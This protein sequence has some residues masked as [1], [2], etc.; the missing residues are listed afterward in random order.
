MIHKTASRP[1]FEVLGAL[2][3][4]LALL[5]TARVAAQSVPEPD[6]QTLLN[7]LTILFWQRPGDAN[8]LLKL[9]IHSGA[10]FDLAGKGGTMA[11][12]G[13]ALFPD[14]ATREYVTEQLGGRLDVTTNYD[15]I[16]VTI[17]G[18][19]GEFE[20]MLE[21]LRGALV[22]TQL[23][24]ENVVR[25]RDARIKHLSERPAGVSEI[26][27]QAIAVRLFGTFPYG[28][29]PMGTVETVSKVD[30]GDLLLARERFLNAD[31][32]T[33]VVIGG[34]ERGRAVRAL[35]QLLGPW[36]KGDR[37]V[38]ATFRQPDPPDARVLV[39]NHPGATA[40]EIRLAV[41]GLARSDRDAAT[42]SL[43]AQIVRDRW[44][45]ASPDLSA[46]FVRHEAHVLPGMFV[47]GA[48]VPTASASKAVSAVR[49]VIRSFAQN[50]ETAPELERARTEILAE[51]SR[52][53]S[54]TELKEATADIWLYI[55]TYKLMPLAPQIRSVTLPDVQRVAARLFKDA[56]VATVLVGNYE[57]LKASFDGSV[58]LRSETP[59]LK[60]AADPKTPAKKP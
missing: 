60:T 9:R 28:H 34:V 1:R 55:E 14:P 11:L 41:R 20:R 16:D 50:A 35:R 30:R 53:G 26:A 21:L 25:V 54:Q 31:N 48:S 58:E 33:L 42:A 19:A 45:A 5:P 12:L 47:L 51:I 15:A 29:P 7:G 56:A 4:L 3:V 24:P 44:Q 40:V 22:A 49:Q 36:N 46:V 27:D 13:D 2:L 57:Q 59:N 17:S 6:R 10:A 23:T 39:V 43:V 8:V 38:P 18:K 32:A 37:T 52:Q